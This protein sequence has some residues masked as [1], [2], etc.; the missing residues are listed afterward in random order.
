MGQFSF[1]CDECGGKDQFDWTS[2]VIVE[3]EVLRTRPRAPLPIIRDW[4]SM[5]P[6]CFAC[7]FNTQN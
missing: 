3:F 2:D 4:H 7:T 1:D 6:Q 5:Y